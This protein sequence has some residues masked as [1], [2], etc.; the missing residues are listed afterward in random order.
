[1]LLYLRLCGLLARAFVRPAA[2]LFVM[3]LACV[4]LLVVIV[5]IAC[6]LIGLA[7]Y[8]SAELLRAHFM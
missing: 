4:Y 8:V 2:C 1:M 7:F 3:W 5:G 6:K